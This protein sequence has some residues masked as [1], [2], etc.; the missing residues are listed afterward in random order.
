MITDL[1][2]SIMEV[3]FGKWTDEGGCP[4]GELEAT[5]SRLG[6]AL[7]EP[8]KDYYVIAGR[9][10][11]MMDADFH[12]T[13]PGL[14]SIEDGYLVF[15]LENQGTAEW[16]INLDNLS[17]PNPRVEGRAKNGKKWFSES[18]KSSAFLIGLGCWQA[19][20]SQAEVARCELKEKELKKLEQFFE[21]VGERSLRL[22]GHRIGLIDR[23]NRILA[24]YLYNSQMLYVGTS[25]RDALD[26]LEKQVQ[27]DLDWL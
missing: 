27:L 16:G 13:S 14:L 18:S 1:I 23:V 3:G 8:L 7:P 22:G 4:I 6:V 12:I 5:E 9:H 21:Y 25:Q 24:T 10:R 2:Q 17:F 20:V 15:C 11:E 26:I 19:V